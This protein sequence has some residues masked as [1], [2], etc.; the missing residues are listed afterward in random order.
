MDNQN[1]G[2]CIIETCNMISS[3]IQYIKAYDAVFLVIFT[4]LLGAFGGII[5][6]AYRYIYPDTSRENN[7]EQFDHN[8]KTATVFLLLGIA[9]ASCITLIV[10]ITGSFKLNLVTGSASDAVGTLAAL[11]IGGFF[12]AKII[13]YAGLSLSKLINNQYEMRKK[14]EKVLAEISGIPD[15]VKDKMG[16]ILT[17]IKEEEDDLLKNIRFTN[18][19]ISQLATLSIRIQQAR[20]TLDKGK[21]LLKEDNKRLCDSADIER[22]VKRDIEF[23]LAMEI[24]YPEERI[25]HIYLGRLY[26]M[27][28]DYNNAIG[29][30]NKFILALKANHTDTSFL[31]DCV[32]AATFNCG[33]Y[34]VLMAQKQKDN[35]FLD[36]AISYL[37]ESYSIYL[38]KFD[39]E[40]PDLNYLFSEILDAKEKIIS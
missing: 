8:W 3:C 6:F 9:G 20:Q 39:F 11:L 23:L 34:S 16:D 13:P 24:L 4:V 5:Y 19:Q 21:E 29:I 31:N 17:K 12:A 35:K 32:A 1:T 25:L 38:G 28:E 7:K 37:K 2:N 14:L 18:S 26:R 10:K 36:N 33:C 27:Q 40:D 15:D 22:L 30:L